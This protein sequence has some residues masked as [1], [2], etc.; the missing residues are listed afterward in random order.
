MNWRDFILPFILLIAAVIIVAAMQTA[1]TRRRTPGAKSFAYLLLAVSIWTFSATFERL[2]GSFFLKL[3]WG[4]IQSLGAAFL[5]GL[6]LL[7]ALEYSQFPIRDNKIFRLVR[8]L[9]F[10]IPIFIIFVVVTNPWHGL[11]WKE[12]LPNN[13]GLQLTITYLPGIVYWFLI[14][15]S[16]VVVLTGA[17]L[18]GWGIVRFPNIYRRQGTVLLVGML[19]PW[20]AHLIQQLYLIRSISV[21]LTSPV[22]LI[23]GVLYSLE[24]Y[25]FHLFELVPIAQDTVVEAMS[26]GVMVIDDSSR[27]VYINPAARNLLGW[28]SGPSR[29]KDDPPPFWNVVQQ[30][31]DQVADPQ[32]SETIQSTALLYFDARSSRYLEFRM[33][34]LFRNRSRLP[35]QLIMIRDVT[36]VHAAEEQIRLQSVA[37][38]A[39]PNVI[40][41][42]DRN[43]II[44]W[45]NP[46]FTRMT[47]FCLDEV[48]GSTPRILKSGKHEPEFYRELWN[49]ILSGENWHGEIVNRT[50]D[51][52]LYIE[53]TTIAPVIDIDGKVTHFIAIMQNVTERKELEKM[54]DDLMQAIVHDL[55]NPI[56]SILFSLDM[57]QGLP[58]A[59]QIPAELLSM[60]EISRE[61][62]WRM[63]G[64]INSM[65]DLSRLESGSMPLILEPVILA[66]L[67]EQT[68]HSQSLI[69]QRREILILN[70]VSYD[71]PEVNVDRLLIS[72]VMQ[73]LLD[74]ALK[75]TSQG[76]HIE[77]TA[78]K[79]FS[80]EPSNDYSDQ[81][82]E[83]EPAHTADGTESDEY[84]QVSSAA[85]TWVCVSIHDN[86]PG[87]PPE[88]RGLLFE[89]FTTGSS[90]RRGSGLGLAFC[91]LA[92]EAH[93][94]RIWV[95]SIE[96]EGTT[97]LFTLP[98]EN[99]LN[100]NPNLE[101]ENQASATEVG[102]SVEPV[103]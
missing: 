2:S 7:F 20:I 18:F 42:T 8:N 98:V 9:I 44:Q 74:N 6:W 79:C 49:T 39:A 33:D 69:A 11:V 4:Q 59:R 17:F 75:F 103:A 47:G 36:T 67:V 89:K 84:T 34:P 35:G 64:M 82:T 54:R 61:N 21:D 87:I 43:G 1:W 51:G 78:A 38:S 12:I 83:K 80:A 62:A 90:P 13:E 15:Y 94:G 57:F 16:Y 100:Q 24:L 70:N 60:I 58:L 53:E 48:L 19:M 77:I 72:R 65:L 66:E 29:L 14:G 37:L 28:G 41:I 25:R 97:F 30:L 31:V 22:F 46:A 32:R 56:N 102:G 68:I 92:V 85:T 52:E 26:E 45:V 27:I 86:G 81:N 101:S 63:L 23:T 40:M 91:R 73:N 93:H 88:L 55:R 10:L 5:P 76:S 50:K 96:G 3:F 99:H 71:L 95:E